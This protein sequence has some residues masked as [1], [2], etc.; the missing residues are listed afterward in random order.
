MLTVPWVFLQ[1]H[2]VWLQSLPNSSRIPSLSAIRDPIHLQTA[3]DRWK[4]AV[5]CHGG[6]GG[7]SSADP[8]LARQMARV[9]ALVEVAKI[10]WNAT[11]SRRARARAAR[12]VR[13]E[14]Y[15]EADAAAGRK[16]R[17]HARNI[18]K[19]FSLRANPPV[20][21]YHLAESRNP[22]TFFSY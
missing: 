12:T 22:S 14:R 4:P 7:S 11:A 6:G 15:E 20:F 1:M 21:I 5:L 3:L 18:F 9:S 19:F 13:L 8:F 10:E 16:A 2:G 17:S